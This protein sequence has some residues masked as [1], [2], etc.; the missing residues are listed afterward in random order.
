MEKWLRVIAL[1]LLQLIGAQAVEMKI[2]CQQRVE[3]TMG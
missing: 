1:L 2:V 3:W